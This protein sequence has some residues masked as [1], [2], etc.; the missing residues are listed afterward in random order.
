MAL[1]FF[2]LLFFFLKKQISKL[3]LGLDR[4][5]PNGGNYWPDCRNNW[6]N[7][8]PIT[9]TKITSWTGTGHRVGKNWHFPLKSEFSC[10]NKNK[11]ESFQKYKGH[12]QNE[13][14]KCRYSGVRITLYN[15]ASQEFWTNCE[16]WLE[17]DEIWPNSASQ[18]IPGFLSYTYV[19]VVQNGQ[20]W[21]R[22]K[23]WWNI[24]Y[25]MVWISC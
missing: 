4:E 24:F 21:A 15:S 1:I 3:P 12:V 13:W 23:S 5:V 19:T 10:K 16:I 6:P 18:K 17:I 25:I 9:K 7:G 8:H 14:K 2:Y 11:F 22:E 20:I